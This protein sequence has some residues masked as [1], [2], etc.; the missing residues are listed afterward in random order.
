MTETTH[1]WTGLID[2]WRGVASNAAPPARLRGIVERQRRRLLL[3]VIADVLVSVVFVTGTILLLVR[4]P[5]PASWLLA[6]NVL[7]MLVA[8]W[9][10]SLWSRRGTWKPLGESTAH[11]LDYARL[12]CQRRLQAVRFAAAAVVAQLIMVGAWVLWGPPLSLRPGASPTI[13]ALPAVVVIVFVV[14]I[15]WQRRATLR[16]LRE[17]EELRS[18]ATL[19]Q[20]F[21]DT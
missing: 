11:F 10:F 14:A 8:A 17:I 21:A 13:A 20:K 1:D 4:S 15:V 19:D 7:L 5:G 9:T 12:H 2:D 18:E 16:E 6:A 3:W